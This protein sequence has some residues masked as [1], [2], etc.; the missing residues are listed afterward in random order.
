MGLLYHLSTS[1]FTRGLYLPTLRPKRATR[2]CAFRH[3]VAVYL[4]F[5]HTR[6]IPAACYQTASCAL[7]ARFHPYRACAWRLFSVTLSV[8]ALLRRPPVRWR[9]ALCCPDFPHV[10]G[11][12]RDRAMRVSGAKVGFFCEMLP[13]NLNLVANNVF[14]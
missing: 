9:A 1:A 6:F 14:R 4:A 11:E 13:E 10:S 12:T 3:Y 5:Q 2:C 8:G 7:T